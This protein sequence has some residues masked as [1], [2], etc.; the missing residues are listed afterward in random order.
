MPLPISA[1]SQQTLP[2]DLPSKTVPGISCLIHLIAFLGPRIEHELASRGWIKH[3]LSCLLIVLLLVS[4]MVIG[5][6]VWFN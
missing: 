5:Y 1:L 2:I 6:Q 4:F 3:K